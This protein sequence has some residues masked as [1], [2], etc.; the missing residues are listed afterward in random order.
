MK[1]N[2]ADYHIVLCSSL[3]K[4]PD[5]SPQGNN[6]LL[7]LWKGMY[8]AFPSDDAKSK[9]SLSSTQFAATLSRKKK[10]TDETIWIISRWDAKQVLPLG[11]FLTLL[12]AC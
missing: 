6:K 2:K 9:F 5:D 4:S 12:L 11:F 3:S 1:R 10:K 7:L 8:L